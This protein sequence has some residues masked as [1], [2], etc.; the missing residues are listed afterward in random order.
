MK[1][2]NKRKSKKIMIVLLQTMKELCNVIKYGFV[3][4]LGKIAVIIQILIPVV[5]VSMNL[6]IWQMLLISCV[7]I[8]VTKYIKEIGYKLNSVTERGFPICSQRFTEVD[9]NGFISIKEENMSEAILY[10]YDVEEYIKRR[11]WK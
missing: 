9:E 3:E 11:G 4:E 8:A 5:L 7:M 10:M 6:N 1:N 2:K